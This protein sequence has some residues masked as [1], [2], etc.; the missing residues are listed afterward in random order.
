MSIYKSM[1]CRRGFTLVELLI[2][3]SI[4][5]IL[6]AVALP[7]AN[8]AR[9]KAKDSEVMSGLNEIQTKLEEY[10]VD[11]SGSYPGAHWVQDSAGDYHV[12]PG[13]IGATPTFYSGE[14]QQNFS[15]PKANDPSRNPYLADGT[16]DVQILDA[17]VANG[18]I[19]D[20]PSNPFLRA[21]DGVK[22]QMG[23]L[24]L[25]NPILGQST[26]TPTNPDS[27]DF[28][29]YTQSMRQDY[30][31]LGRGHFSYIPL[32]PVNNTGFDYVGEWTSGN[33]SDVELSGYY[34]ACRGY[35]LVG[36]GHNRQIDGQAKGIA[37]KYWNSG[38][39]AFDF[40]NSLTADPLERVLSDNSG[41]GIL[42]P[43][44]LDSDGSVGALSGTTANGAPN[45][46]FAFNGAVFI[47]ISGS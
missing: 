27:L 34:K 35:M 43:E 12:G 20:Y 19:T 8:S 28:N 10:A 40:D 3:M 39:G 26:P 16:P 44:M 14:S 41:S 30:S 33:L 15:V 37:E 38:E 21:S 45:I 36:W 22:A 2:V 25:F 17:L 11:H 47:K 9:N 18:Y 6:V 4:I 31:D 42:Y 24:F 23:N 46:D 5:M 1:P 32:N 7:A 29:R 13:V